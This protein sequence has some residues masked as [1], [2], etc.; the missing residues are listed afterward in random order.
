MN[1]ADLWS[2]LK[3][4]KDKIE[5]NGIKLTFSDINWGDEYYNESG[6]E[7]IFE[8]FGDIYTVG[9]VYITEDADDWGQAEC[10]Q[11]YICRKGDYAFSS[12]EL[13]KLLDN[14]KSENRNKKIEE[15]II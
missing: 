1:I 13:S 15:I 11:C 5:R 9:Y 6:E 3:K 4:N 7:C 8:I 12:S 10:Y 2:Y 14:F